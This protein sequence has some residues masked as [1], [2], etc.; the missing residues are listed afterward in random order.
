MKDVFDIYDEVFQSNTD[1]AQSLVEKHI[2]KIKEMD[3]FLPQGLSFFILTDTSR[4]SFPYVSKNFVSNLGLDPEMMKIHGPNYW[5]QFFHPDD[6]EIWVKLLQDLMQ[7][8]M[9]EVDPE[10]RL[11]LSYTWSFRVKNSDGKYVNLFEH[12]VPY[13][14]DDEGKPV[15]GLG[16]L[17]IVGEGEPMPIK[18]TVKY[19]NDQDEYETL[20]VKSYSQKLLSGGLSNRELDIVRLLALDH[21]SK[22]IGDLLS[23]SSHTVDTHRRNILKKLDM[24]STGELVGYMKTHQLY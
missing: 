19:L 18:G 3:E 10:I 1:L 20:Y 9:T 7:F 12:E 22:E 23:I 11:K 8:T 21:S 24:N 15:V 17:T 13:L 14:L 6:L 4:N 16:H 2:Q 5:F